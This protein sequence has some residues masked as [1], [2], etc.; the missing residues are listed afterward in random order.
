MTFLQAHW[1]SVLFVA[2]AV[3]AM[4]LFLRKGYKAEIAEILFFL[5]IRA[6]TEFGGGTGELK[7][8][9]VTTWLFERLPAIAK[10]IFTKAQIDAMIETAVARMKEYLSANMRA[11]EYV[12]ASQ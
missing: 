12:E 11:K 4:A 10:F 6:E 5:V 3:G 9:A 8:A 2:V 1:D 7:F